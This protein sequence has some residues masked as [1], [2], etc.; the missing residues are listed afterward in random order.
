MV[1][2]AGGAG[3][4]RVGVD[5][6]SIDRIRRVLEGPSGRSFVRRTFTPLEAAESEARSDRVCFLAG[7]FAAKEAVF[8]SLGTAFT[9]E[10]EPRDIELRTAPDGR[11]LVRLQGHL[12]EAAKER[13]IGAVSVSLSQDGD[14]VVAVALA[15]ESATPREALGEDAD[16][17]RS[18]APLQ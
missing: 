16:G 17:A 14:Y 9:D 15:T 12:G 11:P 4:S 2:A 6:V 8:K 5:I 7:R 1:S 18:P 3:P 10:D 13:D